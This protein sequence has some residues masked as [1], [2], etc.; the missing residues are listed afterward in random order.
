MAFYCRRSLALSL[1]PL[2]RPRTGAS[3]RGVHLELAPP[4]DGARGLFRANNLPTRET[5][6]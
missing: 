3:T 5:T 2:G 4:T 1:P 6:E